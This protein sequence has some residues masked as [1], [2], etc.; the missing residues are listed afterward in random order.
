[1]E[2]QFVERGVSGSE[3][4]MPKTEAELQEAKKRLHDRWKRGSE[5]TANRYREKLIELY[6]KEKAEKIRHAE[7]FEICEY[8]RR[9][10]IDDLKKLFS[11]E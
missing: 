3:E 4:A 5:R 9:P 2:S 11:I 10:R 7:A 6:G 8:G 1:M